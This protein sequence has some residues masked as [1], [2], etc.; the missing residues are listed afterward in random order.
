[1]RFDIDRKTEDALAGSRKGRQHS[2]N[3]SIR[4]RRVSR[5]MPSISAA[6]D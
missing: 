2:L 6:R 1:M 4:Y 3:F 5:E